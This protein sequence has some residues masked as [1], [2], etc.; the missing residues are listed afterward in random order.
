MVKPFSISQF[1]CKMFQDEQRAK[2]RLKHPEL[3]HIEFSQLLGQKWRKLS[4]ELRDRY[5]EMA[6]EGKRQFKS[7]DQT[8][9]LQNPE[10]KVEAP[11]GTKKQKVF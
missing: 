5:V 4:P 1:V 11:Q 2:L 6:E 10:E 9:V 8:I 7:R 3:N